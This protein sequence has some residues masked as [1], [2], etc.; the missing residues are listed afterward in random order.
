[1][2]NNL[3]SIKIKVQ[4]ADRSYPLTINSTDE[5]IVRKAAK[6]I[7]EKVKKISADLSVRD[8]QDLISI[9][10]LE[11]ATLYIKQSHSATEE[12][13]S[14]IEVDNLLNQVISEISTLEHTLCLNPKAI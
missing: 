14:K 7:S 8:N 11:Y 3:G 10:A 1:M 6:E 4:I 9:V 12:K 5:E 13:N 2:A